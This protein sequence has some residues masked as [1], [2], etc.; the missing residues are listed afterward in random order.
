MRPTDNI[1]QLIKKLHIKA[2]ADLDK[3]VHDDIGKA[4]ATSPKSE[5]ADAALIIWRYVTKGGA[6][7]LAVA[8]GIFI[9]FGIGICVGRLSKP[10]PPPHLLN[11][12]GYTSVAMAHPTAPKAEDSFWRQKIIAAMQHRPYAQS[13]TTKT[14]LLNA[15]KQYLKEKHYD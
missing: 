5:S 8:A 2:S 11:A 14:S 13:Q 10:T 7:K 15:Y 9:V 1:N 3:R 12:A 6:A 4:L